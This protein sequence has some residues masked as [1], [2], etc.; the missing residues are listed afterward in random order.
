MHVCLDATCMP[1]ALGGQKRELESLKLKLW[2]TVSQP[3]SCWEPN[4]CTLQEQMLLTTKPSL[5]SLS[6]YIQSYYFL[7]ILE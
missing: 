2:M 6:F 4:Q 7:L 3:C 1:S 5:Q